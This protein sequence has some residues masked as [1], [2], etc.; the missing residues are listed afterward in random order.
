[1]RLQV[2][3]VGSTAIATTRS[4][5]QTRRTVF[6]KK[7]RIWTSTTLGLVC[8]QPHPPVKTEPTHHRSARP[9]NRAWHECIEYFEGLTPKAEGVRLNAGRVLGDDQQ[10]FPT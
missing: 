4:P 8:R 10:K 1:V 3:Q 7:Q 6:R 9:G 2:I 5:K